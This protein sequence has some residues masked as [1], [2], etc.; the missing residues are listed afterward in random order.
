M[1]TVRKIT[2][3]KLRFVLAWWPVLTLMWMVY[4]FIFIFSPLEQGDAYITSISPTTFEYSNVSRK[5]FPADLICEI[6]GSKTFVESN[7]GTDV[8]TNQRTDSWGTGDSGWTTWKVTGVIPFGA[9]TMV[10]HKQLTYRCLGV[11]FK[12]VDTAKRILDMDRFP[13]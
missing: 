10:V 12:K 3:W 9:T 13:K 2:R 5:L 8:Q 1:E 7:V 11:L 6:Q 4:W